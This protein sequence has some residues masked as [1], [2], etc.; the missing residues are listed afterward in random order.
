MGTSLE[1]ARVWFTLDRGILNE[2][3]DPRVDIPQLRDLGFIVAD[4]AGFW[5]EV[6]TLEDCSVETPAPGIPAAQVV[7]RHPRFTLTQRLVPEPNRD[8]LLLKLTLEVDETFD[9]GLFGHTRPLQ[10][11]PYHPYDSVAGS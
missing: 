11:L 9:M 4:N 2:V 8:V 10:R 1:P 6:K 3:Y 7:H 5:E